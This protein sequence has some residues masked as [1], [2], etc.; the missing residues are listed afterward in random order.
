MGR[1][2][3]KKEP[4][5]K[6]KINISVGIIIAVIGALIFAGSLIG[7][8][9]KKMS[10]F[11]KYHDQVQLV[12]AKVTDCEFRK[13]GNGRRAPRRRY[14]SR[15]TVMVEDKEIEFVKYDSREFIEC[16]VGDVIQVYNLQ[17]KYALE[18]LDLY[19]VPDYAVTIDAIGFIIFLA[20]CCI[21]FLEK[22]DY[23]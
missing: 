5:K 4:E 14:E 2:H 11:E 17:N 3:K 19:K 8:S 9:K 20:G 22:H 21:R 13:I 7:F 18:E 16:S 15:V 1:K 12:D 10:D 23:L 6:P